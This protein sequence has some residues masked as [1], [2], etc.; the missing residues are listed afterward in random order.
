MLSKQREFFKLASQKLKAN[1]FD[2][3]EA[4]LQLISKALET[5]SHE[6]EKP[7]KGRIKDVP[8]FTLA[9]DYYILVNVQKYKGTSAINLLSKTYQKSERTIKKAISQYK[10]FI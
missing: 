2:F 7:I 5:F 4:E 8:Y 9:M 10:D 1:N 3:T 6:P